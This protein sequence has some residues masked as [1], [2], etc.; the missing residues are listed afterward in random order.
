MTAA[1]V[2]RHAQDARN[3]YG[4][5]QVISDRDDCT[6]LP[7]MAKKLKSIDRLTLIFRCV[8]VIDTLGLAIPTGWMG[9]PADFLLALGLLG[10]TVG[11]WFCQWCLGSGSHQ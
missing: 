2:A 7:A 3:G 10:L 6:V 11:L 9:W 5:K 1:T 8:V 4:A